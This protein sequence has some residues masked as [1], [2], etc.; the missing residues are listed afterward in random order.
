MQK[1]GL[2]WAR[3]GR[4]NR[5][6]CSLW[7][8]LAAAPIILLNLLPPSAFP[9]LPRFPEPSLSWD[10]APPHPQPV[11]PFALLLTCWQHGDMAQDKPGAGDQSNWAQRLLGTMGRELCQLNDA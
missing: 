6:S 2:W 11:A 7:V 10:A 3:V 1:L 8:S 9:K 5:L 4:G